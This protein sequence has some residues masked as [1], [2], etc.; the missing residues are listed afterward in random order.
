MY[1]FGV[2]L[3]SFGGIFAFLTFFIFSSSALWKH[4]IRRY[5]PPDDQALPVRDARSDYL[6]TLTISALLVAFTGL[7]LVWHMVYIG[8]RKPVVGSY[9]HVGS[10]R[11]TLNDL[12]K[13]ALLWKSDAYLTEVTL[14]L[15]DE[16]PYRM[17][18]IYQSPSV[19]L[20]F[21][22]IYIETDGSITSKV[23]EMNSTWGRRKAIQDSDWQLDSEDALRIFATN[24]DIR[25]C[26]MSSAKR[27][28]R[29][30]LT[31]TSLMDKQPVVWR[32]FV[33]GCSSVSNELYYLDAQ[34]GK[35]LYSE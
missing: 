22:S 28:N 7:L 2:S 30:E 26:L 24:D 33:P 4:Q 23:Y 31:R 1:D 29:L 35:W 5:M 12:H 18:A 25:F 10:V 34:T 13:H 32:L 27:A 15:A 14:E 17:R 9:P 19:V 20:E 8:E 21:L 3:I 11:S 6:L 16:S